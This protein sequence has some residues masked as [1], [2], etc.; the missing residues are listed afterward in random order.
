MKEN[1]IDLYLVATGDYHMSEYAGD[2]FA[3]REYA[4]GFT[5]SA[6]TLVISA[7]KSALFT[8]GRYFVQAELQLKDTG[9][10]LMRMGV[11]NVMQLEEYCT[12]HLPMHGCIGFDGRTISAMEG[13]ELIE[14]AAKNE[15]C[16]NDSFD[17][18]ESIWTNRPAFPQTNVYEITKNYVGE[19]RAEKIARLRKAMEEQK[20]DVHVIASLDD[21]C[22]LLNLRA[23]DVACNPVLMSYLIVNKEEVLLF[24]NVQ[25]FSKT[26]IEQLKAEGVTL[27]SYD[28]FYEELDKIQ[29][30]C[31]LLDE[32]R[33]NLRIFN[34][35]RDSVTKVIAQNPTVLMKAIK[36]Q[37]EINNLKQIHVQDGL[38]VTKF[39]FWLKKTMKSYEQHK[40]DWDVTEV[41]ASDVLDNLRSQ[42]NGYIELSFPTISAYNE[43]AAQMHYSATNDNCKTLYP[44]GM[45]LV[46]SG[47]QYLQGTTDITR[48]FALGKVTDEMKKYFTLTLKGMMALSHAHF[49]KGCTGYNLDI[50]ARQPLWDVG[51]DYRCGTG[52]GIGYLLNVH[53]APN[54][55]RWKHHMGHND[56]CVIEE[57]MV[58]SNEP[59]VYMDG[60][61][62]IRIE[63]EIV[64][65][66]DYE[67]EYGEFLKFEPLTCVPIDL[68]L[69]D[70]DLLDAKDLERINEYHKNVYEQL[71]PYME[72]EELQYLRDYT[73]KIS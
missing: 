56:L 9:I 55:F 2:Y 8:D 41:T 25:C 66:R 3:E 7:D 50:L 30:C 65:V 11:R 51:M 61:F 1:H 63:N 13:Q 48:T 27:Y 46:D 54:G 44:E 60:K 14:A 57:G 64:C 72:G 18:I 29:Q 22:W 6:G 4:S 5:G 40:K 12:C 38:A 43:N 70:R 67:N 35:F 45:L 32:K 17:A 19:S 52:H 42:I 37:T 24:A 53:E 47:G 15:G 23:D 71:S 73:Q 36:N 31:V 62:G 20:A 49:L 39:M 26:L 33:V 59:G 58:T 34:G 21:I 69:I 68:D 16:I 28:S 10:E